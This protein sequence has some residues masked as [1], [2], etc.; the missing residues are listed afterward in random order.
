MLNQ[1]RERHDCEH[2]AYTGGIHIARAAN[3]AQ[4]NLQQVIIDIIDDCG[5]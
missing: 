3:I 2:G 1:L 4:R 5:V